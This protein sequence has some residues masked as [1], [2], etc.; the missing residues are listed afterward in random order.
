MLAIVFASEY[1]RRI[2][3]RTFVLVTLLVPFAVFGIGIAVALAGSSE[4]DEEPQREIVVFDPGGAVLAA[5]QQ[6]DA[7]AYRFSQEATSAEQAKQAVLD[8]RYDGLLSVP[9]DLD[10]G[11]Y[12]YVRQH[13]SISERN[14]LRNFVLGIV[15]DV[16]L[17]QHQLSPEL[18]TVLA[19][20]PSFDVVRLTDDG[21]DRS[22]AGAA[23]AIGSITAMVLTGF[24]IIYGGNVMQAVMEEKASR[25]A[26]MVV[27]AVRPFD[28]LM[29]KILAG[30]AIG[31]TQV[32]AWA[33]LS[34]LLLA[35]ASTFL[36]FG[37]G[38]A[39]AVSGQS[40]GAALQDVKAAWTQIAGS[41]FVVSPAAVIVA[42][43]LLPFGFLI[44]ASVFASLGALYENAADAQNAAFVAMLPVMV[45]AVIVPTVG[46]YP[47]GSMVAFGSFFPFSAPAI[48]P[49]RMLVTDVPVWQI[50]V[51]IAV[52]IAGSLAMVW[53]A[54]RIL[55]GSLLMYGKTPTLRDFRRI[56]FGEKRRP[57]APG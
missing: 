16:R 9:A 25:M 51:S 56:L 14:A 55:R 43:L 41:G 29:G 10:A 5:L 28:L 46:P 32:A 8:D 4:G 34:A 1:Q 13:G 50:G 7:G 26:E 47:D 23:L 6:A 19:S 45:S 22:G 18:R 48:L 21:E 20:R 44:H 57:A 36:L 31:V 15:R 52:C 11:F 3:T 39:E 40:A 38:S 33:V 24:V 42:L 49:A 12:F 35:A 30:A 2:K 53:L 17:N 37:T 27:S 54:G